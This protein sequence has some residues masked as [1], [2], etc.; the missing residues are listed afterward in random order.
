MLISKHDL[1][2]ARHIMFSVVWLSINVHGS[3]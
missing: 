1:D 3:N 2:G